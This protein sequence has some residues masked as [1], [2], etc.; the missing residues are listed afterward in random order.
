MLIAYRTPAEAAPGAVTHSSGLKNECDPEQFPDRPNFDDI[1]QRV[2]KPK[3]QVNRVCPG[4]GYTADPNI[5]GHAWDPGFSGTQ[6]MPGSW[7]DGVRGAPRTRYTRVPENIRVQ[8]SPSPSLMLFLC[9]SLFSLSLPPSL[10]LSRSPSHPS[11]LYLS[12]SLSLF[13]ALDVFRSHN[14]RLDHQ[15]GFPD[16]LGRHRRSR[17]SLHGFLATYKM[18]LDHKGTVCTSLYPSSLSLSDL[19][20]SL[21]LSLSR[22]LSLS[23]SLFVFLDFC[24]MPTKL[25]RRFCVH[26]SLP[27]I[28]YAQRP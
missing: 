2:V 6:P 11:L 5:L 18:G 19:S 4:P 22:Y 13:R 27:Q 21:V 12:P 8:L 23:L 14:R 25:T 15:S 20:L 10:P 1:E 26:H 17:I 9:L 7:D 16:Q 24:S 28:V 3:H